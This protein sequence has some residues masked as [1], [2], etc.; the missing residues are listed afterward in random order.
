MLIKQKDRAC[1]DIVHEKLVKKLER[2][3]TA[4]GYEDVTSFAAPICL[5]LFL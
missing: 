2:L 4:R 1:L 3:C 5:C